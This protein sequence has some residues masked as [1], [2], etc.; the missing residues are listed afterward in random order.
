MNNGFVIPQVKLE[1][2]LLTIKRAVYAFTILANQGEINPKG[3]SGGYL[4]F[5]HRYC[6]TQLLLIPVGTIVP[7]KI[8]K[9]ISIV[10]KK[11]ELLRYHQNCLISWQCRCPTLDYWGGAI[12]VGMENNELGMY[13]KETPE[14]LVISF[15]GL[16][17]HGDEAVVLILA[18]RCNLITKKHADSLAEL[19]GNKV[20]SALFNKM[21][22][23]GY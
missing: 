13:N 7:E 12:V 19:S 14:D 10:S 1:T 3:K 4:G 21:K 5:F 6:G 17:E 20:F 2:I 8:H 18:L 15:S 9:Y 23:L 16:T 11:A 22:E